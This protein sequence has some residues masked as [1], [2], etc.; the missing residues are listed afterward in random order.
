MNKAKKARK[1][2]ALKVVKE[3]AE[4]NG[5]VQ[6]GR[7]RWELEKKKTSKREGTGKRKRRRSGNS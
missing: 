4:K 7:R 3:V 6:K 5:M 2:E 1:K